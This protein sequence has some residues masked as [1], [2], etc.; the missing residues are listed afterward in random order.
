MVDEIGVDEDLA[1]IKIHH[2]I[3]IRFDQLTQ[4][5]AN[6]ITEPRGKYRMN[7]RMLKVILQSVPGRQRVNVAT[8]RTLLLTGTYS[9]CLNLK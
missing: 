2:V 6:S 4:L 8:T 5:L 9:S 1:E 7:E 3:L